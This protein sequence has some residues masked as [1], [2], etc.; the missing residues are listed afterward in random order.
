MTRRLPHPY[1]QD[2]AI[3]FVKSVAGDSSETVFLIE[4]DFRPIG[5]VGIDWRE[6]EMPELGYWLG[7]HHGY[8]PVTD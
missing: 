8:I 1:T 4:A 5:V 6:P 2:D 3:Q 7:V